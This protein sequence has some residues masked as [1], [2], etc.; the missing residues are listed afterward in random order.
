MRTENS[1]R[2]PGAKSPSL[3]LHLLLPSLLF[4]LITHNH[5]PQRSSSATRSAVVPTSQSTAS[6]TSGLQPRVRPSVRPVSNVQLQRFRPTSRSRV[7]PIR[8][9]IRPTTSQFRPP[10][11]TQPPTVFR[12]VNLNNQGQMAVRNRQPP[13]TSVARPSAIQVKPAAIPSSAVKAQQFP[14]RRIPSPAAA[15]GNRPAT[16][17]RQPP[18]TITNPPQRLPSS[19][20]TVAA[21]PVPL[22]RPQ[23]TKLLP[24]PATAPIRRPI[25]ATAPF[26]SNSI[27]VPSSTGLRVAQKPPRSTWSFSTRNSTT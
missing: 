3:N 5:L 1:L 23:T 14:Q 21:N 26:V 16:M 9:R 18:T 22:A 15:Q 19:Q 24:P 25:S 20:S 2:F 11:S 8:P 13:T 4:H 27:N 17:T 10:F 6:T 7:L 12:R